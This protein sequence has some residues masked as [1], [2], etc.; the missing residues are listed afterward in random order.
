MNH[1]GQTPWDNIFDDMDMKYYKK[2]C[3]RAIKYRIKIISTVKDFDN[4]T[5][6]HRPDQNGL[7]Q[8]DIR[9]ARR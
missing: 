7:Q 2:S 9:K 4:E 1:T 6:Q 3:V 5:I 8:M